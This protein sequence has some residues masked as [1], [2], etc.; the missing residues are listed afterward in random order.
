MAHLIFGDWN[1]CGKVMGLAPWADPSGAECAHSWGSGC[2]R[3]A[4]LARKEAASNEATQ[5]FKGDLWSEQGK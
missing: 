2:E 3:W 4:S 1:A 5:I